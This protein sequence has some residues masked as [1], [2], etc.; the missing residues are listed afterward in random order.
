MEVDKGGC[1]IAPHHE[2]WEQT[3]LG[4]AR[5]RGQYFCQRSLR[6]SSP[7]LCG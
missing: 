6:S 7:F 5:G 1:V 4:A 3:P 2:R